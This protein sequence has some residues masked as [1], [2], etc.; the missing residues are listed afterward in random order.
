[1]AY[2][3]SETGRARNHH[4]QVVIYKHPSE[5]DVQTKLYDALLSTYVETNNICCFSSQALRLDFC[6]LCHHFCDISIWK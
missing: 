4:Q 5:R 6:K 2:H 1:M 3:V